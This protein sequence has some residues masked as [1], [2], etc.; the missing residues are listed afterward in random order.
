[1]AVL[2]GEGWRAGE[3]ATAL[4]H[5]WAANRAWLLT[6]GGIF[7]LSRTLYLI[8]AGFAFLLLPEA[9]EPNLRHFP[10]HPAI[11]IHW[12]W[13]AIYYS[14]ITEDGYKPGGLT[15]FFPSCRS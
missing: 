4:R 1:M 2:V 10:V 12:R 11:E 15:A 14:D 7:L 5:W 9:D 3:R 6:V 13:D 8:V